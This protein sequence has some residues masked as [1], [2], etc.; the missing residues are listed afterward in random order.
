MTI[1]QSNS[2]QE[3]NEVSRSRVR[4]HVTYLVI[5][6]YTF[7]T[8]YAVMYLLVFEKYSEALALLSGLSAV[9]T[10]IVGFW[11][12]SRG[13]G[14]AA[15]PDLFADK[16]KIILSKEDITL[17]NVEKAL[18]EVGKT[19]AELAKAVGISSPEE[20]TVLLKKPHRLETSKKQRI[21]EF[22]GVV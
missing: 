2:P 22:F 21:I 18:K 17:V 6:V 19:M 12:G 5:T 15:M 11:F 13:A 16:L 3:E 20:L 10:G 8:A 7:I 1:I 4:P 9:A 14:G